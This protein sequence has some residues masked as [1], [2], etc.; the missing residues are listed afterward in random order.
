MPVVV[1]EEDPVFLL[2]LVWVVLV[3]LA[4]VVPVVL[5]HLQEMMDLMELFLP[6]AA[7]AVQVDQVFLIPL[8][9]VVPVV[10]E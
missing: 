3:D 6:A 1:E 4:A 8:E 9:V 10:P 7:V 5:E 2:I